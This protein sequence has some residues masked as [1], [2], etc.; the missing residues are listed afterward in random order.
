ML[1][2]IFVVRTLIVLLTV[3]VLTFLGVVYLLSA[4]NHSLSYP[5]IAISDAYETDPTRAI[6]NFLISV[7]AYLFVLIV[8]AR[9]IRLYPFV[10]RERDMWLLFLI[11]LSLVV[12]FLGLMGLA[13][14]PISVQ[15]TLHLVAA[16]MFFLGVGF[17]VILSILL[18]ESINISA[19]SWLRRTRIALG[20][21]LV[22]LGIA[23][24]IVVELTD[25]P[26]GILEICLV[27]AGLVYIG[28]WMH[29]SEF[30]IKS[31][32][33]PARMSSPLIERSVPPL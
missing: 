22:G 24:A 14:V 16:L 10:Y 2:E 15:R 6:A 21:V 27:L 30:P 17:L 23:L 12:G 19:P 20:V 32:T 3:L 25:A 4:L 29:E 11:I 33:L 31:E 5:S 8:A 18:D 26:T 1:S 7:S 13:A 28:T 9:L